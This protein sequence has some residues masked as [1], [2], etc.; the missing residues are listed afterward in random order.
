MSLIR[1]LKVTQRAMER[2]MLGVYLRGRIRNEEIPKRTK[3]T[4]IAHGIANLKWQ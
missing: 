3:A 1:R 2:S 4:D